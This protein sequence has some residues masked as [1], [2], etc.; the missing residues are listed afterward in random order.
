MVNLLI[1]SLN[2]ASRRRRTG[3][4]F[5]NEI[6]GGEIPSEFIP[7]VEKG[8]KEAMKTGVLAGYEVESLKVRLFDGSFHAVD[9]DQLSFEIAAKSA[10]RNACKQATQ[11]FLSLL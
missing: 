8:F 11:F 5:V 3:L 1:F 2:W 7:S 9:S 6:R 10:F 4:E